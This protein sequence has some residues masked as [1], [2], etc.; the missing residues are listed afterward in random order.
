M[1]PDGKRICL[2]HLTVGYWPFKPSQ[3]G[4]TP[5]RGTD[6]DGRVV[7]LAELLALNQGGAGSSPAALTNDRA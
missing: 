2:C 7:R 6:E 1:K 5:S 4:S 3:G